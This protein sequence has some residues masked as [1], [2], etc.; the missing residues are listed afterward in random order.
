MVKMLLTTAFSI[1][2]EVILDVIRQKKE[3]KGM[4]IRKEEIKLPLQMLQPFYVE[5]QNQQQKNFLELTNN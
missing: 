1:I 2:L 5:N 3:I 4:R